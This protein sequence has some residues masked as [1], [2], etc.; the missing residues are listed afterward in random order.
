MWMAIDWRMAPTFSM[1]NWSLSLY[2]SWYVYIFWNLSQWSS[3]SFRT[4]FT[5][6]CRF[7]GDL[8]ISWDSFTCKN[9]FLLW[10]RLFWLWFFVEF[11]VLFFVYIVLQLHVHWE[12]HMTLI[13]DSI[14]QRMTRFTKRKFK[15]ICCISTNLL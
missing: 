13:I 5:R 9:T 10:F 14:E 8:I 4:L 11:R 6:G 15:L 12:I 2:N 7:M 1:F 3:W